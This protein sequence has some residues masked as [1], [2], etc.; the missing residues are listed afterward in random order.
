VDRRRQI[1]VANV[2]SPNEDGNNDIL[3]VSAKP[4]AVTNILYFRIY[5][6]WGNEVY[7]LQNFLPNN[8]TIG[9]DG[10]FNGEPMNPG[11][12]VWSAEIEFIDGERILYKGDVTVVR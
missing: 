9:W 8:P 7:E 1:Y 5:D 12:F 3:G 11:V 10:T 6:R 2:F 4:G